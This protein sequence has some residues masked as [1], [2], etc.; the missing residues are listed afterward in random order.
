[1]IQMMCKYRK[2][3]SPSCE[4]ISDS[5]SL[6]ASD[7]SIIV[8]A[9]S[10][11]KGNKFSKR[12]ESMLC[13]LCHLIISSWVHLDRMNEAKGVLPILAVKSHESRI[14]AHVVEQ[15]GPVDSTT[16]C[17]SRLVGIAKI[18]V[19][20]RSSGRFWLSSW[21]CRCPQLNL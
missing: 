6:D 17:R 3:G 8:K 18:G 16:C 20:I 21:R 15:K 1:M 9:L 12:R 11:H 5:N 13:R 2:R 10:E 19:Q 4:S 14:S 7:S